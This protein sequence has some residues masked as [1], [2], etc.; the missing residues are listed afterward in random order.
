MQRTQVDFPQPD[1]RHVDLRVVDV[2]IVEQHLALGARAGDLLMHPVDAAHD[3]RLARTR[4]AD[5][6]R[7][8]IGRE[9]D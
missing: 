8:L 2:E 4:R 9:L 3:G 7:R 6:R 5:Q 1:G